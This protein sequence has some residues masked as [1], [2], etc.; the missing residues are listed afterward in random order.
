MSELVGRAVEAA[1]R[2]EYEKRVQNRG[3]ESWESCT[4]ARRNWWRSLV[5]PHVLVALGVVADHCTTRADA[6]LQ[7]AMSPWVAVGYDVAY[8]NLAAELRETP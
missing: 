7:R 6:G 5:R 8:R 2:A 1:A 3:D 4:E